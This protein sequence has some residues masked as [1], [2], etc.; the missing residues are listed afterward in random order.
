VGTEVTDEVALVLE[1]A[2][3]EELYGLHVSDADVQAMYE[4][5]TAEE[6]L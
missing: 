3:E 5:V 2:V 4:G 1:A 6:I